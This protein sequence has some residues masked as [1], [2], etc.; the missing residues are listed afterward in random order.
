MVMAAADGVLAQTAEQIERAC[1]ADPGWACEQV[2]DLTESETLADLADL[3]FASAT[4]ILIV[5]VIAL[6]ARRVVKQAI[7]RLSGRILER[8]SRGGVEALERARAATRAETISGVFNGIAAAAIWGFAGLMI[9]GEFG[10]NLG[11]LIAGAGIVGVALG[12]GAQNLVSDF[13]SGVFILL[14][15]QYGVGDWVDVGD[16]A[17]TVEHVGLRTTKIRDLGG[18]LWTVRNGQIARTAN[19]N[20]GWGRAVLDVGVAYGADLRQS[21]EIIKRV[22]DETRADSEHG[23]KFLEEPEIWGIQELGDDAV[24]IRL[25]CK[26]QPGEQWGL[27]R[28]LRLR[29]KEALD[30]AGV[31]IPFANRTVWIRTEPDT[32]AEPLP[33]AV[34]DGRSD[35]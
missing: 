10:I 8:A 3:A 18:L 31:E 25:V 30:E 26:T 20:Q 1:G 27:A 29:I 24:A 4:Q 17:G 32:L 28:E 15:D 19:A 21:S 14:D 16:C 35:E 34:S 2:F 11:P 13:L 9:L 6:I 22:A 33:I 7:R 23:E 5:V 12:F